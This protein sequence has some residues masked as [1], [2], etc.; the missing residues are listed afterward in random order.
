MK[1][2]LSVKRKKRKGGKEGGKKVVLI[3]LSMSIV[4]EIQLIFYVPQM[5]SN[6]YKSLLNYIK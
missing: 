4:L 1:I 3:C 2:K 5:L 6:W